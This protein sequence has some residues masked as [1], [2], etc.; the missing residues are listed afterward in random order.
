MKSPIKK[1]IAITLGILLLITTISSASAVGTGINARY[2]DKSGN[3]C[4]EVSTDSVITV[5]TG[6]FEGKLPVVYEQRTV[7]PG[8]GF[9]IIPPQPSGKYYCT[10]LGTTWQAVLFK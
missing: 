4:F 3:A 2:F 7:K 5:Q 1:T 10:I 8:Y 9:F 6:Y